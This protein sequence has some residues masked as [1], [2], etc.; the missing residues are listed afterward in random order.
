VTGVIDEA[1]PASSSGAAP[2]TVTRP[3]TR[4]RGPLRPG[5]PLSVLYLGFPLWWALGLSHFVFILA[6]IPMGVHLLKRGRVLAPR[7][8][9]LWLLFLVWVLAG[10]FVLWVDAPGTAPE[11]GPTRMIGFTYRVAW[12]FACT[13]VMLYVANFSER[14]LPAKRLARLLGYMFVVTAVSGLLGILLPAFEMT[15]LLER[16]LPGAIKSG[17]IGT[18]IHPAIS[19]HTN[20]LGVDLVRPSGVFGFANAWGNN[21][22]M[23]LP[24]FIWSW[25]GSGARWRRPLSVVVLV[26]AVIPAVYSVNRGLWVG[27]G[28]AGLYFAVR[29]ALSGRVWVLQAVMAVSVVVAAIFVSSPLYDTVVLRIETPHSNERRLNVTETVVELTANG[30]PVMGYGSTRTLEGSFSSIAAAG[31][32]KCPNCAAPPLGTQGFMLRLILT[33]GFVG[34]ALA[35]GFFIIQFLRHITNR[36]PPYQIGCVL[37]LQSMLY[38]FVYD[39]LESPLF[40]LMLAIG[41]MNRPQPQADSEPHASPS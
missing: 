27:L 34:M 26:I 35:I 20:F 17:F 9:A 6:A 32:P 13:T 7:G 4:A 1:R 40:T 14:E 37:I 36:A 28:M 38:F 2:V 23:F 5:W 22:A 39:S 33:T 10:V 16:I 19:E 30:S 18:L 15:S 11:E 25:M 41:L 21:L 12:Y 8:F 31:T 29:L 3:L 24:F